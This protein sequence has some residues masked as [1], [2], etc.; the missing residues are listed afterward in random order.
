MS[1]GSALLGHSWALFLG[2]LELWFWS[3]QPCWSLAGA[4]WVSGTGTSEGDVGDRA[5]S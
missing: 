5:D 2:P 4:P 1:P 3:L